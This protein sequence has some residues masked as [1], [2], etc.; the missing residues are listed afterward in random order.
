M[1]LKDL[2]YQVLWELVN[3]PIL[4]KLCDTGRPMLTSPKWRILPSR[5]WNLMKWLFWTALD[6]SITDCVKQ[7]WYYWKKIVR[8]QA[9][10]NKKSISRRIIELEAICYTTGAIV[11]SILPLQQIYDHFSH[12]AIRYRF[13]K[14]KF[15]KIKVSKSHS[16]FGIL[17]DLNWKFRTSRSLN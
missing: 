10:R 11:S 14:K 15:C 12:S 1:N 5:I 9:R 3:R 6:I 17:S 2:P 8:D 7:L 16:K 13:Q 4:P